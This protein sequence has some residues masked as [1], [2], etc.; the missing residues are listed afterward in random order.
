MRATLAALAVAAL[1]G[2]GGHGATRTATTISVSKGPAIHARLIAQSH[3]PL[4][5]KRWHYEVHV[6]DADGRPVPARIHLQFLFGGVPVGQ[7]GRHY[8]RNGVWRETIGAPG[9]PPFPA[10]ARGQPLVLQAIVTALG[11]TAK[12]NWWIVVK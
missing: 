10:R 2:C 12:A 3:H 9:N 4:V 11:Q 8:V 5:G 1:A 6:T 7:V